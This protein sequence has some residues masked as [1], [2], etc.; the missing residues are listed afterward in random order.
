[1]KLFVNIIKTDNRSF[2]GKKKNNKSDSYIQFTMQTRRKNVF[3]DSM[4]MHELL[5]EK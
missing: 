5:K 1:M 2:Q 3:V 4:N